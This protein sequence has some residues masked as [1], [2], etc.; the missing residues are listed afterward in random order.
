MFD[1]LQCG[2]GHTDDNILSPAS[3]KSLE[4]LSVVVTQIA[5][6]WEHSAA[7]SSDGGVYTW[8]CGYKDS[9]RGV[10]PPVLGLGHNEGRSVPQL[11][12]TFG[13]EAGRARVVKVGIFLIILCLFSGGWG[14]L[15]P[16]SF[17]MNPWSCSTINSILS[18]IPY[19]NHINNDLF[20]SSRFPAAGTTAWR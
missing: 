9:R 7:L 1:G 19:S 18:T 12:P 15:V 3:N 5:A 13:K 6:G 10:V 20:I 17:I 4:T 2:L 16:L 8:G 11:V 14:V